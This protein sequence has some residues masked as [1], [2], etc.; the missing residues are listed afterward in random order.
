MAETFTVKLAGRDVELKP[1]T[2]AQYL[3]VTRIMERLRRAINGE[4]EDSLNQSHVIQASKILDVIDS[5]VVSDKDR[6]FLEEAILSGKVD[7]D[8]MLAAFEAASVEPE[9]P[10][11][12]TPPRKATRGRARRAE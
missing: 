4:G 11:K 9:K 2:Y 12:K 6:D 5:M 7:F 8:A 1:P 10:E 3:A